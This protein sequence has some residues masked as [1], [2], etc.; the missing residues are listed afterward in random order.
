MPST[1]PGNME[2]QKLTGEQID[3]EWWSV[4]NQILD[5]YN[6][7]LRINWDASHTGLFRDLSFTESKR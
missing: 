6:V 2:G 3:I 7:W 1:K 5:Y 4:Y